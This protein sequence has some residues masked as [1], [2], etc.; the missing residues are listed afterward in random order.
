MFG[1]SVRCPC[2]RERILE[3]CEHNIL[4]I[5]CGNFT[6]FTNY[7]QW[8]DRNELITSEVKR[9]EVKVTART[10]T[11]FWHRRADHRSV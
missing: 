5:T 2:M 10:N 3:V 7:V 1:L 8:G 9:S 11:L 6:R 4:Q